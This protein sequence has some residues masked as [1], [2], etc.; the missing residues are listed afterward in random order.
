MDKILIGRLLGPDQLGYYDRAYHLAH[1]LP[2]QLI[3]PVANVAIATWCKIANDY[4]QFR[5]MYLHIV[6]II[7]FI[8]MLTSAI[9]TLNAESLVLLILGPQWHTTGILL[10]ILSTCIG[11]MFIYYTNNW[12]HLSLATPNR[13]FRWSMFSLIVT[14]LFLLLG[15]AFGLIGLSIAYTLSY[16]VLI[17]PA[18]SYAGRPVKLRY[19][20][21]LSAVWRY[22]T[23]AMLSYGICFGG[24]HLYRSSIS[25][26]FE[27]LHPIYQ[28]IL[29]SSACTAIYL[30]LIIIFYKGLMP[31]LQFVSLVK[32]M[33]LPRATSRSR[34][35]SK[36]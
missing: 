31:I 30:I 33:A 25:I 6:S 28:L 34:C 15:I 2:S 12:L 24:F 1:T 9:M 14:V 5:R 27:N 23:A 26:L 8:G 18:L 21:V 29:S 16:Y 7:A 22:W 11:V 4:E 19:K 17:V 10:S 3:S 35:A 32:E 36:E 20:D 13:M